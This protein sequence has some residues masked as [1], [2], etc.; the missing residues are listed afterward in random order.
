MGLLETARFKLPLLAVGQ[1]HKEL[2]HNAALA[3]VDFLI[4]PVVQ[5]IETDP[6][7]INP[8]AG[9]S[10]L[11]GNG[12]RDNWSGHDNKIAGWTENGWQFFSPIPLM[13]VYIE[14]TDSFAIYREAWQLTVEV[15][16]PASGAVIDV[17][18]R[19]T[20]DSILAAL[21]AQGILKSGA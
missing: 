16:S 3:R 2:F 20:I 10:W 21:E 17:E 11:V 15:E 5:A 13:R 18:A 6:T 9:Q 12:A 14:S 1:A 4:H 8:V 7:V 19:N